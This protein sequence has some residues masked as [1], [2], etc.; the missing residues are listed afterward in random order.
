MTKDESKP[1]GSQLNVKRILVTTDFSE[2]SRKAFRYAAAFAGQFGA[3]LD[4]LLVLEPVPFMAGMEA[5][6]ISMDAAAIRAAAEEK[7]A[8]WIDMEIPANVQA[9][10]LLREGRAFSEIVAAAQE[11]ASDLIVIS[12]HGY[13]GLKH[14]FMG[15]TTERVVRHARCPVLV[16]RDREHEFA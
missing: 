8:R 15:S 16:V 4:V 13:T 9:T 6:V 14:V 5:V 2:E 1:A 7:L 3:S 12:T 10:P 11:R